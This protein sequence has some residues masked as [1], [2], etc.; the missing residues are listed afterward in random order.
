[1]NINTNDISWNISDVCTESVWKTV[2]PIRNS[3]SESGFFGNKLKSLRMT[4]QFY[5]KK[6]D[7]LVNGEW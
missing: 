6:S 5:Q 1:M 4:Y 7:V 2:P 3:N